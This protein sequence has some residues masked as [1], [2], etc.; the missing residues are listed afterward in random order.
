M[1]PDLLLKSIS[2][3]FL[4]AVLG[5]SG[6]D[7]VLHYKGNLAYFKDQFKNSPLAPATGLLLPVVTLLEVL[8]AGLALAGLFALWM[9]GDRT[10]GLTACVLGCLN[11]IALIFG[12]RMAQDY[13]GAAGIVPYLAV[14]MLGLYFFS[15]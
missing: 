15:V 2:L 8:S 6:L 9:Q 12:Q 7:K 10:L 4:A 3:L 13:G 1:H 5:Q 14:A 11:F